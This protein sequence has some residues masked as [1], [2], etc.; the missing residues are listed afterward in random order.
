MKKQYKYA[1]N[2]TL[3]HLA[4]TPFHLWME[5][6]EIHLYTE[7][8]LLTQELQ[9]LSLTSN[10][11]REKIQ[12]QLQIGTLKNIKQGWQEHK[13]RH[14]RNRHSLYSIFKGSYHAAIR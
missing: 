8:D 13:D 9:I 14:V 6:D 4:A 7:L 10:T 1:D 12:V 11:L 2:I 3:A 5:T